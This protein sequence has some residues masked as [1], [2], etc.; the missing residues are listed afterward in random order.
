[1]NKKDKVEFDRVISILDDITYRTSS[2]VDRVEST[3]K[4]TKAG[5]MILSVL[6]SILFIWVNVLAYDLRDANEKI[7]KVESDKVEFL[8]TEIIELRAEVRFNEMKPDYIR[9]C[10]EFSSKFSNVGKFK[11]VANLTKPD[12]F[13]VS[14]RH[15]LCSQAGYPGFRADVDE[16]KHLLKNLEVL[17]K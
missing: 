15:N 14:C 9:V 1:M 10:K 8:H 7:G 3:Q 11:Y 12:C 16:V 17:E 5:I 4:D 6:F 13:F 2:R